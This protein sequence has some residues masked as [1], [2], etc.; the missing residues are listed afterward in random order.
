MEYLLL[1]HADES[2]IHT[3]SAE[4]VQTT[5]AAMDRFDEDLT[6]TGHNIGSL[7]LHPSASA[8]TVRV[9][10][11]KTLKSDGPFA[12]TK[13]QLGGVYIVEAEDQDQAVAIA[14]RLPTAQFS[15]IEV[16]A[17]VGIDLKSRAVSV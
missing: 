6:R 16:R 5:M 10:N 8:T 17:L 11:G 2:D 9:R 4:D 1:I 13:E 15:T 3:M 7:R 12:E 14:E